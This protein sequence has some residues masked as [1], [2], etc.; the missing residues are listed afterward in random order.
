MRE[1]MACSL[2]ASTVYA[3]ADAEPAETVAAAAYQKCIGLWRRMVGVANANNPRDIELA[4]RIRVQSIP[5]VQ[6]ELVVHILDVRARA[7]RQP[8]PQARPGI[9]AL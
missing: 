3:L 2:D 5:D 8:V 6:R 7:A 9:K 1:A 4:E